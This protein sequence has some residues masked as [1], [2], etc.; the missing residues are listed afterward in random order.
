MPVTSGSA[1]T[2][3][4]ELEVV[5]GAR[6]WTINVDREARHSRRASRTAPIRRPWQPKTLSAC[7]S[8]QLLSR[9]VMVTMARG[10]APRPG[11][12][13]GRVR[14]VCARARGRAPPLFTRFLSPR[15]Q[16]FFISPS[17]CF[18]SFSPAQ[19]AR[20]ASSTT[21]PRRG[22]GSS[23]RAVDAAD[24]HAQDVLALKICPNLKT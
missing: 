8:W 5:P 18:V 16:P 23:P 21:A 10:G 15:Y 14:R 17:P 1:A 7:P 6:I 11:S 2:A 24:A 13:P 22:A 19:A 9:A 4:L 20:G 12:I 3:Q